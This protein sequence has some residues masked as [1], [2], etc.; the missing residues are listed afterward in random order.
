M[1]EKVIKWSATNLSVFGRSLV[2]NSSI[3]SHVWF[4]AQVNNYSDDDIKK[5]QNKVWKFMD[6]KQ[7]KR[8]RISYSDL[9]KPKRNGGAGLLCIKTEIAALLCHWIIRIHL[10]INSNWAKLFMIEANL[11]ASRHKIRNPLNQIQ[12]LPEIFKQEGLIGN[13]LYHWSR[14]RTT[15]IIGDNSE[16]MLAVVNSN[17]NDAPVEFM[18]VSVKVLYKIL[19]GPLYNDPII[20]KRWIN[21]EIDWTKRWH[22]LWDVKHLSPTDKQFIH[23]VWNMKLWCYNHRIDNTN[24]LTCSLCQMPEYYFN[25]PIEV[26][27]EST[28]EIFKVFQQIW[29]LWTKFVIPVNWW[30][31]LWIPSN[32]KYRDQLHLAITILKR[33][34]WYNYTS[35]IYNEEKLLSNQIILY[36]W[37]GQLSW[38]VK[39]IIIMLENNN[40]SILSDKKR[41]QN[42]KWGLWNQSIKQKDG[43]WLTVNSLSKDILSKL[44][45]QFKF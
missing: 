28:E 44:E 8:T 40:N 14:I 37:I 24:E 2:A 16:K 35:T 19:N 17:G 18:L 29:T 15:T 27:C 12:C 43:K 34:I 11:I 23:R 20:P 42:S 1:D 33:K 22:Y 3:M 6:G 45:F 7:D 26:V 25:H 39:S 21:K 10:D 36:Q 13:I 31:E 5:F 9:V 32:Y 38:T 30:D 41:I 4:T